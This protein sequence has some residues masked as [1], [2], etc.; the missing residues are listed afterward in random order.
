MEI[1]KKKESQ[2]K[3]LRKGKENV[4][5]HREARGTNRRGR[6]TE[7]KKRDRKWRSVSPWKGAVLS[8]CLLETI[9]VV[10][11]LFLDLSLHRYRMASARCLRPV[12][13]L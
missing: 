4:I 2:M 7:Y 12:V 6:Q 8:L 13:G 11:L 5:S 3:R 9:S 1:G 10:L